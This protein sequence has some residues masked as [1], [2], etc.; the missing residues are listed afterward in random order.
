MVV[1]FMLT[2]PACRRAKET[3]VAPRIITTKTGVQMV[4]IP[5]GNFLMGSDKGN[6][7][8]SPAHKVRLNPFLM[9]R[10]EV[11]QAEFK[12]REIS[13]PSHFK[14]PNGPLDQINWTDA[15]IY[16]NERSLAEGLELCY[17]E[18]TWEC[19][20]EADGY[21]LPTEAEWEYACRAGT[22]SRYSF[23]NNS[24]Q[25]KAYA[26]FADNSSKK[27]HPVGSK[28]PNP[29]GLYD[30]HGNVA[31]WCNDFYGK[32][33]Y[34]RSDANDPKGP[35]KGAERV[36]RGGA[37]NSKAE[38][39]RSTYRSSDPSLDD[40]CLANDAIG[41][42]CVRRMPENLSSEP[43]MTSTNISR[44]N[45][46]TGFVYSDIYLRHLTTPGHP[47][48]PDRLSAI[49]ENLTA[50]DFYPELICIEPVSAP[51]EWI[52]TVHE[53]DYIE[54]VKTSCNDGTVYLDSPDCPISKMSYE[55]ALVAAG[56]VLAAV[57][58]VME[59]NV[60][61][62]FCAV[63]PPGHHALKDRAMGF[64]IFNNIAIAARY[65]QSKYGLSNIL[66]VDWDVHHGNGTQAEFYDDPNVLYF[67]VHQ[68][69]FYPGSGSEDEKGVGAGLNYTI[70]VPLPAGT[71][72]DVYIQ[73]FREKLRP[74]ALAFS[75]D[76]VLVSAGFD[77]HEDDLLGQMNVTA[78]GFGQMTE[79]VKAIATKCCRGRLVSVLEG[80]YHL[81]GLAESV[82]SHIRVLM[83]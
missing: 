27:T 46:K 14:D 32:D 13:D 56:G 79:I 47:E 22:S 64:C 70:N 76:F 16:C 34:A 6:A 48:R 62:A 19:D 51:L 73:A 43:N 24:S 58:A 11:V 12:K 75:P 18:Q 2:V 54:R 3:A 74:A 60:E 30:M 40:T 61:N 35:A 78:K 39:C 65:I 45:R 33:Y 81:G 53:T 21:R 25:L 5:G 57:D 17:D 63:R 26:W 10:F 82:E 42:R 9:D 59:E 55:V 71:G 44:S 36:L 83:R 41:F 15:A 8:E 67:S 52:Q 20:F 31:E 37:W 38:A 69:P 29:W 66:I 4:A 23:G 80:G 7:D 50:K 68:Y 28:K 72:D 49:M 77:A 1:L